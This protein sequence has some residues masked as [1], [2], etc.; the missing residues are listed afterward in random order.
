MRLAYG[1]QQYGIGAVIGTK[2]AGA[3]L[4]GRPFLLQDGSLL[5]LAV[6][7][8]FVNGERLEGKGVVPDIEVPFQLE[9]A[10]GKDPQKERAIEVLVKAM[11][12]Q[13]GATPSSMP[14][15]SSS[16]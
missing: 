13:G 11:R 3:V 10:Q 7:N 4:G 5:Y 9:Y 1:F 2:T 15:K 14:S 12:R 16:I 6:S 8:V